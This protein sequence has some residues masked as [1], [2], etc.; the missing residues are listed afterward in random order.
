MTNF[1]NRVLWDPQI[2]AVD[3]LHPVSNLN[4]VNE[5][6][7]KAGGRFGVCTR[8]GIG[9]CRSKAN[10]AVS[11]REQ[12]SLCSIHEFGDGK[13][14]IW[15]TEMEDWHD[16]LFPPG[17]RQVRAKSH[18][19]TA[20]IVQTGPM[21]FDVEYILQL[22]VGGMIPTWITTPITI[23]TLERLFCHARTCF[24]TD[25]VTNIDGNSNSA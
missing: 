13:A 25:Q 18:L 1:K 10:L 24:D 3:E 9:Y 2:D 19:F 6:L 23:D 16:H 7:K 20:T 4:D 22:E 15:G 5:V 17:E 12:L 21:T 8:F 14:I 11:A